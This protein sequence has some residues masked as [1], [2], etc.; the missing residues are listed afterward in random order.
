MQHYCCHQTS[1][2]SLCCCT[3]KRS[4]VSWQLFV[5]TPVQYS[6]QPMIWYLAICCTGSKAEWTGRKS[7]CLDLELVMHVHLCVW[8]FS[9]SDMCLRLQ[10][11]SGRTLQISCSFGRRLGCKAVVVISGFKAVHW[12]RKFV[13]LQ[14]CCFKLPGCKSGSKAAWLH[15]C[16]AAWL[17]GGTAARL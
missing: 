16:K 5:T 12:D 10:S 17:H 4:I 8:T 1:M 6:Q 9:T 7:S 13:R 15:G 14:G 2:H 11:F 3:A